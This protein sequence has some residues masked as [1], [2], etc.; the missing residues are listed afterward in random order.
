MP[1]FSTFK[2]ADKDKPDK[3]KDEDTLKLISFLKENPKII[4]S[5]NKNE[6]QKL[7]ELS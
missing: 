1:R 6:K 7:K 2:M 4:K 3:F 5:Q